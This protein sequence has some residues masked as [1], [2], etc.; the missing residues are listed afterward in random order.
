MS[1]GIAQLRPSQSLATSAVRKATSLATARLP[2]PLAVVAIVAAVAIVVAPRMPSAIAVVR[3]AIS[4]ATAQRR[5]PAV[6]VVAVA[7]DTVVVVVAHTA[8]VAVAASAAEAKLATPAGVL[9]T[10]LGTA[11]KAAS[12]TTAAGR[13]I[14]PR[15]ARNHRGRL[16]T[17]AGQRTTS[18]VTAPRPAKAQRERLSFFQP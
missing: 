2:L 5:S 16:A 1:Q 11:S 14:F 13:A 17:I 6:V 8:A 3:P 12:A 7:V 4:R 18:P 10:F 15:I 9:D